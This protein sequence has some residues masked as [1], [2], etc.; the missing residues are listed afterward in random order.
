MSVLVLIDTVVNDNQKFLITFDFVR[1]H[2]YLEFGKAFGIETTNYEAIKKGLKLK[3]SFVRIENCPSPDV[4]T[5]DGYY[6]LNLGVLKMAEMSQT[7]DSEMYMVSFDF[8]N[9]DISSAGPLFS[10]YT[11]MPY[12][13]WPRIKENWGYAQEEIMMIEEGRYELTARCKDSLARHDSS[14]LLIP[15]WD[16]ENIELLMKKDKED[17]LK[18]VAVVCVNAYMTHTVYSLLWWLR[19]FMPKERIFLIHNNLADSESIEARELFRD[20]HCFI[21]IAPYRR[22]RK[23]SGL[24][25]IKIL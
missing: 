12:W 10:K 23:E 6:E 15:Y 9:A 22:N 25:H 3:G 4:L 24:I 2:D 8:K 14:V 11:G 1:H 19:S 16:R 7:Q 13:F 18:Y 5:P 21:S 20:K 17:M